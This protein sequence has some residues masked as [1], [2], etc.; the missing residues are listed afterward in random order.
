MGI[1]KA[2]WNEHDFDAIKKKTPS[3]HTD[4]RR[5]DQARVEPTRGPSWVSGA[6]PFLAVAVLIFAIANS[7]NR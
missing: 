7:V 1:M 2:E 6:P 5:L 3:L 4:R